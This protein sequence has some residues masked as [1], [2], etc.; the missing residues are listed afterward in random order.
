MQMQLITMQRQQKVEE[1][2]ERE[3]DGELI[4][5]HLHLLCVW[6][7]IPSLRVFS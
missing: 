6:G 5:F 1:A 3:R 2:K 4:K 7:A